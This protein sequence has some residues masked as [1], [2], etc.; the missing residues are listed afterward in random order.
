MK[1]FAAL[2]VAVAAI[3]LAPLASAQTRIMTEHAET[4]EALRCLLDADRTGCRYDFA[5]S[6]SVVAKPWLWWQT[7]QRNFTLGA[8]VSAEYAGTQ[9]PNAYTTKFLSGRTADVY[10]VK[11]AHQQKTFYIVPPGADGKIQYM[12][13]RSGAPDDERREGFVTSRIR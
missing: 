12:L 10:D 13:I 6:A 4:A 7:G 1:A 11:F 8:L 9:S 3:A 5:G 2:A